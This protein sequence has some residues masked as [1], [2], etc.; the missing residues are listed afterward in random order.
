MANGLNP[1]KV[2]SMFNFLKRPRISCIAKSVLDDLQDT[3]KW[4]IKFLDREQFQLNTKELFHNRIK[5]YDLIKSTRFGDGYY[6]EM[7]IFRGLNSLPFSD[8]E[9]KLILKAMSN[10]RG[11]LNSQIKYI[12]DFEDKKK[13]KE[14]FPECN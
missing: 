2:N 14:W 12:R 9:E 7:L 8:R 13:L 10:L 11:I 3:N 6:G 4:D 5:N 1:K